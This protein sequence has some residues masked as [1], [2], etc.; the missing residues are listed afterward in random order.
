M[1]IE[2]HI[3]HRFI[4]NDGSHDF[5]T[6][7]FSDATRAVEMG[8]IFNTVETPNKKRDRMLGPL[9]YDVGRTLNSSWLTHKNPDRV[10][11]SPL[12]HAE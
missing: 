1:N 9:L 6:E 7:M 8:M 5:G 12:S 11:R 3:A 4:L 10:R 2:G